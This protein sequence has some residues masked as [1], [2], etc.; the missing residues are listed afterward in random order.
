MVKKSE[1]VEVEHNGQKYRVTV[2][3]ITYGQRNAI[4]RKAMITKYEGGRMITNFD[5]VVLEE[6]VTV[7]AIKAVE[8]AVEDV[9]KWLQ[10]L[11]FDEARKIINVA[12]KMN[13][14][15]T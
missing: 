13:P 12:L 10:S 6:E 3:K 14:L 15:Q 9:R 1:V 5:Y 8:P 11:E 2:G 4:L 7:A